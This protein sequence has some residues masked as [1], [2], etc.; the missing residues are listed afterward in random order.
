[1]ITKLA[2]Y[3]STDDSE[4]INNL[5]SVTQWKTLKVSVVQFTAQIWKAALIL[6]LEIVLYEESTVITQRF[7]EHYR[8]LK[9]LFQSKV[10][11]IQP[12]LQRI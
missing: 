5:Y 6:Y 4:K 1:M 11:F 10:E 2:K 7:L 12:P 9:S 3:C 8:F